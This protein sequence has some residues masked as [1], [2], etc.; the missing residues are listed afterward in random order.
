MKKLVSLLLFCLFIGS[1]NAGIV[2]FNAVFRVT[3]GNGVFGKSYAATITVDDSC[4]WHSC[5]PTNAILNFVFEGINIG[6]NA[7]WNRIGTS[8]L[9][10]DVG[11]GLRPFDPLKVT[12]DFF[13]GDHYGPLFTANNYP[14]PY[15]PYII[16]PY[17]Y[18]EDAN[19]IQNEGTFEITS[20][21]DVPEPFSIALF[22]VALASLGVSCRRK[23]S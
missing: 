1:A 14:Y 6:T 18:Y 12:V 21:I 22:G 2:G 5:G 19:G 13:F 20:L 11:E 9:S 23:L 7:R 17:W 8:F 16:D 3:G 4:I 15:T 10:Y